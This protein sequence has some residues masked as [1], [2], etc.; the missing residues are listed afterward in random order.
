MHKTV[1]SNEKAL[2][3]HIP[4]VPFFMDRSKTLDT[5]K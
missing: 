5:P 2:V 3:E 4:Q 1:S